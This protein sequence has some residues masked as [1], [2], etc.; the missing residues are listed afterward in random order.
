V[1]PYLLKTDDNSEGV[2]ADV[3]EGIKKAITA[4]C[5]HDATGV[6]VRELP[7]KIENLLG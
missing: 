1:P 7:V 4:D 2:D 3:F 5:P 6:R